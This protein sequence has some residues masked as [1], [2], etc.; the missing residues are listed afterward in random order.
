MHS[1]TV[2]SRAAPS[3]GTPC[4]ALWGSWAHPDQKCGRR[5]TWFL[6]SLRRVSHR[7]PTG[8][9][10]PS[11]PHNSFLFFLT[12]PCLFCPSEAL[13]GKQGG[14]SK[15]WSV[16]CFHPSSPG[17]GSSPTC[18]CP[19]YASQTKGPGVAGMH[20]TE[21]PQAPSAPGA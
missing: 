2:P 6:F 8:Y 11:A 17:G 7:S 10:R 4:G 9:V 15:P 3:P 14:E 16:F 21:K 1:E 19:P 13:K 20:P 5:D 12:R 18:T